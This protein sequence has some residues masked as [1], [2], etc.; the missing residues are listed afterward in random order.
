MKRYLLPTLMIITL[1]A[2]LLSQQGPAIAPEQ[3]AAEEQAVYSVFFAGSAPDAT[4]VIQRSPASF[5]DNMDADDE[6]MEYIH[7]EMLGLSGA[8]LQNFRQ[9]NQ[10]TAPFDNSLEIGV[11]YYL[12]E[13]DELQA[14]FDRDLNGG[15]DGWELFYSRFPD[16]PGITELSRVGF[17]PGM[18]RALVYMGNQSHWVAGAG[19]FYLLEKQ[20]GKWVI[21]DE[22]MVWIS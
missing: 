16:S 12:M 6:T 5:A 18:E 19:V 21:I 4:V 13:T 1:S 15:Q 8:L 11:N 14:I 3:L 9:R 2:C 17:D 10:G 7:K 22:V 20:A